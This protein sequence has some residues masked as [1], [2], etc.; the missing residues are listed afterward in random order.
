MNVADRILI[1]LK[2]RAEK[3]HKGKM[4]LVKITLT[5]GGQFKRRAVV[6]HDAGQGFVELREVTDRGGEIG[7]PVFIV[8]AEIAAV[9]PSWH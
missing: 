4:P 6:L 2:R 3:D 5:S 8:T 9:V 1:E 7:D